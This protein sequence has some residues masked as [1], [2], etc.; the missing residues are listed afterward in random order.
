MKL[1]LPGKEHL[2][3]LW[4]HDKKLLA[5]FAVTTLG[6]S[7]ASAA[8]ILLIRGFLGGVLGETSGIVGAVAETIGQSAT[9]WITAGILIAT[10]AGGALMT[11]ENQ[12][13]QQHLVKVIELRMM[14]RLMRHMM[15]LSV[16]FIDRQSHG[17]IIQAIRNDTTQLRL[18]MV[19][20]ANVL[21]E[22]F[23]ALGLLGAAV[24][25]SP[26]LAFWGLLVLPLAVVPVLWVAR[27]ALAQ[28]FQVR[29]TGYV[30]FDVIL[31]LLR[32]IRIIKAFR[33]EEWEARLGVEKGKAYFDALIK[34]IRISALASVALESAA[35]LGIVVVI[36]IGGF[37]VMDGS[38][39]WP[40][41]LAFV[42]ALRALH[43]PLNNANFHYVRIREFNASVARIEELLAEKP[44]VTDG[45]DPI[46]LPDAPK[47]IAL[48]GLGFDYGEEDVLRDVA[49]EVRAGETIGIVGRSGAGKTTLLNLLVRF[50]DPTSG[51]VRY[52]GHDL[53]DLV[54][55]DIYD[56]IAI[57][58]QEP[59]LFDTT[60]RENIRCGR[61]GASDAEVEEASRAAY[62]HDEITALPDG[63]DTAIGAA[64]R[65]L[66]TG[67][68]QR[69]NIA[70]ALLKNAPILLLDEA[71]SSLDSMAEVEVH[72]AIDRL[73]AD[74]TTFIVA[75]RLSTLR[76]ADRIV[77]LDQGH[78][79][80]IGRHA[81][82]LERS[83][84][85]AAIW[86]AQQMSD[87]AMALPPAT[88]IAP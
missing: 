65:G 3:A 41:L 29:G 17:D 16:L 42:M 71:T 40:D 34:M 32:G 1:S 47:T 4:R 63:Y 26:S 30:L 44:D 69:V 67:Q 86:E 84:I 8:V 14:E 19:S 33:G 15:S 23:V 51:C 50:Y 87:I 36:L 46:P 66:S 11:Y 68:K 54:L 73:M 61:P 60:V 10:Y 83:R 57:V 80:A 53:R 7:F 48:E 72:R 6:R 18:V 55:S 31:Q 28:S 22:G 37:Q 74:R 85:Y 70:R 20:L 24:W 9:I 35:G 38:L 64:Y 12:V 49:F 52:D 25:L 21:L 62:V 45:P 75:H 79:V 58:I 76:S 5:R 59:F 39:P 78:C 77:V 88:G 43:G 81:E 27:R 13:V 82:L 56:K 2:L